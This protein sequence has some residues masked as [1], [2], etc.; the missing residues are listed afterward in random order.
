MLEIVQLI[1]GPIRTN[2][3]LVADST[4]GEAAVIDPAWDGQFIAKEAV[5]RHWQIRQLWITHAHYDH[6]GGVPG[7]VEALDEP[8]VIAVHPAD[9]PLWQDR[10]VPSHLDLVL[11]TLPVPTLDLEDDLDLDLGGIHFKVRHTPGHTPGH[12]IF[13]CPDAGTCFCGDLIFKGSVG[14]TD[15]P[16]GVWNALVNSIRLCVYTLPDQTRLLP[17]HGPET[18]VEEEKRYNPFV[19]AW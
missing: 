3:F 14:R 4:T 9:R 2:T 5:Q 11:P 12:C 15:L 18:S 8:P 6:T 13:V 10:G 7:L 1:L 16:G 19:H 17:G